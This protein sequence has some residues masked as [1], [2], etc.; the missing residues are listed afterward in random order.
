MWSKWHPSSASTEAQSPLQEPPGPNVQATIDIPVS[1]QPDISEASD[2]ALKPPDG[3]TEHARNRTRL[4]KVVGSAV[5]LLL[6][7]S[8]ALGIGLGL[9]LKVGNSTISIRQTESRMLFGIDEM[10]R[11]KDT[12]PM[13]ELGYARYRGSYLPNGVSQFLGMRYARP[14]TGELRWRAPFSPE[15]TDS[16]QQAKEVSSELCCFTRAV[17]RVA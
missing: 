9:G 11:Q 13:I 17:S 14:P 8:L 12:G 5:V 6:A 7:L 3:V 16:T 4:W 10:Q 15:A 1:N 2:A